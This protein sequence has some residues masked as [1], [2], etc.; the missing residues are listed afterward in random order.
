MRS[1]GLSR[2][3]IASNGVASI[4]DVRECEAIVAERRQDPLVE[5][6]AEL[7]H[8]AMMWAVGCGGEPRNWAGGKSL[9]EEMARE[10]A[11][12]II[13]KPKIVEA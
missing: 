9:G 2:E 12:E 4:T 8:D 6:I 10:Y 7:V 3:R 5:A 1:T 11:M 13:K